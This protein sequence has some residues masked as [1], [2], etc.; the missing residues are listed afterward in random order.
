ME[1]AGLSGP[2]LAQAT[3]EVDPDGRGV[4]P[5]LIGF[6]TCAG[7]SARERC[8][9]HSGWLIA[10]ALNEPLQDLFMPDVLPTQT[11]GKQHAGEDPR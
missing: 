9:L 8:R 6:L 10:T 5:A 2:E 4:S 7:R 1:A 3:R 11:K